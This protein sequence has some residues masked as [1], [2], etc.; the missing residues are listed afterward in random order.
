[1][2]KLSA[3]LLGLLLAGGSVSALA[4]PGDKSKDDGKQMSTPAK[5]KA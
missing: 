2:K 4:C 5:P 3:L 1:M